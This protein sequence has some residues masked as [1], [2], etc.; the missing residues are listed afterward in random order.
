M[1][2]FQ[3]FVS[4]AFVLYATAM[5]SGCAINPV[6][7]E[8]QLMLLSESSELKMG[9]ATDQEITKTYGVHKNE[10]LDAYLQD[11]GQRLA[12]LSHRPGLT[13]YF[14]V[15][16]SPVVNAFAVPGGYIY[17]TRG[18]L[19]YLDSE[20]EL[21]GV[22]GHEIGHVTARHSAQ[23]YSRA[24]I[25][26]MGLGLGS[27]FSE[28]FRRYANIAQFGVTALFLKYSRDNERQADDLG[29]EYASKAGY[30]ASEMARFFDTLQR[31][32]PKSDQKGLPSWLSTH[33]DPP[34]RIH[35]VREKAQQ[36]NRRL[37]VSSL[38][39]NREAY[40]H[41]IDGLIFGEDPR[42]GYVHK[43]VFYHPELRFQFPVPKNWS[44]NNTPAEVKMVHKDKQGAMVF[45]LIRSASAR[46][47]AQKFID[48]TQPKVLSFKKRNIRGLASYQLVSDLATQQ[49]IIRIISTFIEHQDLVY[50][51]HGYTAQS[52]FRDHLSSFRTTMEGFRPL[53]D[54]KR[55]NVTPDRLRIRTVKRT[56]TLHKALISL[57]V[58]KDDLK[59]A[60]LLNG[61]SL[62]ASVAA[63]SLIKIVERGQR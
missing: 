48:Q 28:T 59:E 5:L 18:I 10:N 46:A 49:G 44:L 21:A 35:A 19:A 60:A 52:R 30:D 4:A 51:F 17:V 54:E 45:S 2:W 40:L 13:F 42:Q 50:F 37:G 57:G 61:K 36:W 62:T 63:G 39:V 20:A 3:S 22:L 41:R 25:A 38:K 32:H 58:S 1:N 12:L 6:T 29:V 34:N 27:V 56:D 16:D 23:Q 24:Q 33:P 47:A 31:L 8:Q 26:Q 7:G 9:K 43:Q 15:L 14:Q 55:R 11:L 53:D